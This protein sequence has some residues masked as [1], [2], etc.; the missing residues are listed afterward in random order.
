MTEDIILAIS[1]I[2]WAIGGAI[3]FGGLLSLSMD[4]ERKG[5]NAA[6]I[7]DFLIF[8]GAFTALSNVLRNWKKKKESAWLFT[9]GLALVLIGGAVWLIR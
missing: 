5:T 8:G 2:M 3:A 7:G 9:I 6:E 1:V 4:E